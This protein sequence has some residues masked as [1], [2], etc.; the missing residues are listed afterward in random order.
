SARLWGRALVEHHPGYL[1]LSGIA[2]PEPD[3]WNIA[4][5]HG[6]FTDDDFGLGRSS[7]ITPEDIESSGYDYIALG[8]IHVFGEVSRGSTVAAYCGTPAPLY[9]SEDA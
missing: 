4:L 6:F 2:P 3:K 1:P 8:H 7:P 5:A 9:A